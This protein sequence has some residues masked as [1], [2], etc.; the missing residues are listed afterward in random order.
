MTIDESALSHIMQVLTDLYADPELAV[1]R[2]YSTNALDAHV[3]AGESRPIE[4]T[5]PAPLSPFFKVRDYGIGLSVDDI[6]DIYSRYGTSTKRQSDD[7]VGMLGLGCKSALTYCDQFTLTGI[8]DGRRVQVSISRDEDGSG[9][10]TIVSE[11]ATKEPNGVEVIVPAK[12]VNGFEEKAQE[13]FSVWT[14]GTVLVNGKHP[15]RID[16]T[17]VTDKLLLTNAVTRDHVVMGNVPY[18]VGED[19]PPLFD[20]SGNAN[21]AARMS[22]GYRSSRWHTVAFVDIGEVHFTPSREALQMTKTTKERL[23]SIRTELMLEYTASIKRQIKDAPDAVTAITILKD[24]RQQG[25]TEECEYQGRIVPDGTLKRANVS[26][27]DAKGVGYLTTGT[28]YGRRKTGEWSQAVSMGNPNNQLWFVNFDGAELT[29]YKR[30]K[31]EVWATQQ[32]IELGGKQKVFVKELTADERFWLDGAAIHDFADVEAIKIKKDTQVSR[33][34]GKPRGSYDGR[35]DGAWTTGIEAATI[36][37]SKPL[38]WLNGNKWAGQQEVGSLH[39]EATVICL[40]M[41]RIDKF[42]RDF[43]TAVK[44]SEYAAAK[45]EKWKA[46][47]KPFDLEA[48]DFQRY[49]G[50]YT[51]IADL[52]PARVND[53]QLKKAIKLAK[54]NVTQVVN[55]YQEHHHHL[56]RRLSGKSFSDP[57]QKYPLASGHY[58]LRGKTR[59]HIYIYINAA[60]AAER[61]V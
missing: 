36:D 35:Q 60:Y 11:A 15:E 51:K 32:S 61:T 14:P 39:P 25:F 10:M 26:N 52:D 21:R 58:S 8:K 34:D 24:A 17:W 16:G 57:L 49:G 27:I 50:D 6:R 13:F 4:V 12:R 46:A 2:E 38:I 44:L 43:P 42:Q 22:Y 47:Q 45:A 5:L 28:G 40:P 9:S 19:E 54:H 41:N 33:W 30:D 7:V 1:I 48:F 56:G 37:A 29:A 31:L 23:A 20:L 59:E 53:P 55:E 18:P 3:E